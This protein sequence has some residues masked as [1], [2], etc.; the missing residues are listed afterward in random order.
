M[1]KHQTG[2]VIFAMMIVMLAIVWLG[3]GHVGMM[4]MGKMEDDTA[5]SDKS[6]STRQQTKEISLPPAKSEESTGPQY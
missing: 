6:G 1:R 4:G 5:H 2:E 3:S